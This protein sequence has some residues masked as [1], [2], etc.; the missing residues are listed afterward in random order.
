MKFLLKRGIFKFLRDKLS[1]DVVKT[2]IRQGCLKLY[3]NGEVLTCEGRRVK[4]VDIL[5]FGEVYSI[6]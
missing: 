6:S 1:Y 3:G 5:L 2:I 4:T